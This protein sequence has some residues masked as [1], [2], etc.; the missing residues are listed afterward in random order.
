M[1]LVGTCYTQRR[2]K[3]ASPP[4]T[5]VGL[6]Q[7]QNIPS[8]SPWSSLLY[9]F[10]F[11]IENHIFDIFKT[12]ESK[13]PNYFCFRHKIQELISFQH[14]ANSTALYIFNTQVALHVVLPSSQ[15]HS[16]LEMIKCTSKIL[17]YIIA[18]LHVFLFSSSMSFFQK[19]QGELFPK[20]KLLKNPPLWLPQIFIF[21]V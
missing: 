12:S 18:F 2:E 5:S 11:G 7:L 20:W 3:W 19:D 21:E 13:N 15:H 6:Q 10:G 17:L 4:R 1:G 9:F 16:P 14:R 8:P